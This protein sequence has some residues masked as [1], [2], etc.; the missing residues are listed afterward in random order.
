MR[1]A[2]SWKERKAGRFGWGSRQAMGVCVC[3]CL[4]GV[5]SSWVNPG[6]GARGQCQGVVRP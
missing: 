4:D 3:V 2:D 6:C 5:F 1:L